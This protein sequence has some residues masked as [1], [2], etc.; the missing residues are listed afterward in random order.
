MTSVLS[1]TN[2]TTIP[3]VIGGSFQGDYEL[4]N[5]YTSVSIGIYASSNCSIGIYQ[6]HQNKFNQNVYSL[7]QYIITEGTYQNIQTSLSLPYCSIK[8]TNNES[9]NQN[10]L[11]VSTRWISVDVVNA[12]SNLYQSLTPIS[13][14]NGF[15]SDTFFIGVCPLVDLY[16]SASGISSAL[17]M[18]FILQTSPDSYIWVN[19]NSA[20]KI[21]SSNLQ[22]VSLIAFTTA[23]PFIRL[24]ADPANNATD[25]VNDLQIIIPIKTT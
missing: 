25:K 5:A 6:S 3:L 24:I 8:I 14:G 22:G 11:I 15:I 13:V 2:N 19:S 16:I 17:G 23:S 9:F 12:Y 4:V 7:K 1:S 18:N 21:T 20:I 10:I